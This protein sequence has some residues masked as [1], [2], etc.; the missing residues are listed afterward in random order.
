MNKILYASLEPFDNVSEE[1]GYATVSQEKDKYVLE[2][3]DFMGFEHAKNN[4]L[5]KK[6]INS[7]P[8][9]TI[10]SKGEYTTYLNCFLEQF[11]LGFSHF[12]KF[13]ATRSITDISS[14][15]PPRHY[16]SNM[17]I[18]EFK[19]YHPDLLMLASDN[20]ISF[21]FDDKINLQEVSINGKHYVDEKYGQIVQGSSLCLTI[22][23]INTFSFKNLNNNYQM[24]NI[25]YIHGV[26]DKPIAL[27]ELIKLC[28]TFDASVHICTNSKYK[29]NQIKFTTIDN[30]EYNYI[31]LKNLKINEN[32]EYK[33]SLNII[34]KYKNEV[35]TKVVN[36]FLKYSEN[37]KN[38]LFPFL[39]YH[40]A[41]SAMEITYLE[42]F[43]SIEFLR[44]NIKG[45]SFKRILRHNKEIVDK[46]FPNY[47]IDELNE[48]LRSLR[49][50]YSHEGYYLNDLPIPTENP[51]RYVK[52][53]Y[54]YLT[55]CIELVKE[56][57][58]KEFY[59]VSEIEN[60][61]KIK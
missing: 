58:V 57:A 33:S 1:V 19:Y 12:A 41:P 43:R 30:N 24:R 31:D 59:R 4:V 13:S 40:R 5:G 60:M 56:I 10:N 38:F 54:I 50:Y 21:K 39:E 6:Y 42:Y 7:I 18:Q 28:N 35:F 53:D 49:N 17:L 23:Y 55:N 44:K 27:H 11:D 36:T 37:G 14:K 3:T 25:N 22:E 34:D 52:I 48:E 47:K 26:L 61:M 32:C 16:E 29:C 2:I 9:Y 51:I 15:Y 8:L 20:S 46:Y 45:E